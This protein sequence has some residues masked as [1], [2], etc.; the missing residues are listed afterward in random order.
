MIVSHNNGNVKNSTLKKL[1]IDFFENNYQ[2]LIYDWRELTGQYYFYDE[3]GRQDEDI[4]IT[5]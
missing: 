5:V 1:L 4:Y 3:N 2:N